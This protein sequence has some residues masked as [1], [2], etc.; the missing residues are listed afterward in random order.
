MIFLVFLLGAALGSFTAAFAWRYPRKISI[1]KV[2]HSFCENCRHE[3]AWYDNIP[4]LSFLLLKGKC[5]YCGQ[6]ISWVTFLAELAGGLVAIFLFSTYG[7]SW[8]FFLSLAI[9]YMLFAICLIDLDK[10]I[11]PDELIWVLM[12][13][14]LVWHLSGGFFVSLLAGFSLSFFLLCLHLITR[15]KG[16]GLGDVKLVIPLGFFLGLPTAIYFLWGSFMVGA[17]VGIILLL[18]KRKG[19]KSQI[20]FGPFLVLSFL[21]FWFKMIV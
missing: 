1:V 2:K 16:M 19:L 20:P 14:F 4:L 7:L 18:T 8:P 11:I 5:R 12:G 21:W 17:V 15:G 10:M 13:I 3:L 6:K 9:C